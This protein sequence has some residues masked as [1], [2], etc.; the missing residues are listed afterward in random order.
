M[1]FSRNTYQATER[2]L[3]QLVIGSMEDI[4]VSIIQS[5]LTTLLQ[6]FYS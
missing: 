1:K 3:N 2:L 6:I 5:E 4:K